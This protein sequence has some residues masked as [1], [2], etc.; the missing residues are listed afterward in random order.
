M[1]TTSFL[2]IVKK[3]KSHYDPEPSVIMQRYK[4]NTRTR[5]EG[6]SV[7]TYIAEL[8]EIAQHCDH[9]DT[10]SDM[11]RDR[12]ACGVKHK[13]ITNRFLNDKHLIMT[14]KKAME[15]A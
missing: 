3:V 4:F 2:D 15:L 12:L 5:T 10:L 11:L 6:E 8:R 1:N 14:Y 7:A 9:K 13:G